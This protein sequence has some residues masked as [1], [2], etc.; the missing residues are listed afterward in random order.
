MQTIPKKR[1][2]IL[3]IEDLS[4]ILKDYLSAEDLPRDAQPIQFM[5]NPKEQNKLGVQFGSEVWDGPQGVQ[6]VDAEIKRFYGVS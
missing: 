3:R 2:I 1:L 4:N 5:I 6:L